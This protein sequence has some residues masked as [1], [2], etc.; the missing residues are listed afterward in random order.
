MFKHTY[1]A[2]RHWSLFRPTSF[3]AYLAAFTMILSFS[4]IS[5]VM[6]AGGLPP[7]EYEDSRNCYW[8]AQ[9]MGNGEGRSF[10]DI[11]GVVY[12]K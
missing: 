2:L 5:G 1:Y 6:N 8:D 4:V 3:F 11:D 12:Y 9:E 7:C 10:Y